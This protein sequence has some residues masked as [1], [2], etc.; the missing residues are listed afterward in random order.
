MAGELEDGARRTAIAAHMEQSKADTSPQPP[1]FEYRNCG[2]CAAPNAP[3]KCPCQATHYCDK[4]CQQKDKEAHK[5]GCTYWVRKNIDT[6][7]KELQVLKADSNCSAPRL[8]RKVEVAQKEDD[9]AGLHQTVGEL[10]RSTLLVSNYELAEEPTSRRCRF[11]AGWRLCQSG[12]DSSTSSCSLTTRIA[13]LPVLAFS[14]VSGITR[15]AKH[16]R[17]MRMRS[18]VYATISARMGSHFGQEMIAITL[19]AQGNIYN[20]QSVR[21]GRRPDKSKCRDAKALGEEALAINRTLIAQADELA[22]DLTAQPD[23]NLN[24]ARRQEHTADTLLRVACTYVNL[25]MFDKAHSTVQEAMDLY[26]RH[27]GNESEKV[28]I[29][30]GR[31]A[32]IC[33][34]QAGMIET[35]KAQSSLYILPGSRVRVEGLQK[36]PQYNALEGVVLELAGDSISV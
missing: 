20:E 18:I 30:H 32:S 36:H 11:I 29:C 6:L 3:V 24:Q 13:R 2:V 10:L 14:T 12:T 27:N 25:E 19:T 21:Q 35:S 4:K 33:N 34:H 1:T 16:W 23:P 31:L 28:A 9:L 17:R 15:R 26:S 7:R 8:E 5:K 22:L